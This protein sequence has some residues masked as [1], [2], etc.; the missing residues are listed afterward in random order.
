[1]NGSSPAQPM[2]WW[3]RPALAP[4]LLVIAYMVF[5]IAW[6]FTNPPGFAP[7]E[8]EHYVKAIGIAHGEVR[9]DP[10]PYTQLPIVNSQMLQWL[11][12]STRLVRVPAGMGACLYFRL[13]IDGR[14]PE[15]RPPPT[16]ARQPTYVASYPPFMYVGAAAATRLGN[17]TTT[18]LLLGRLATLL[19]SVAL[20]GAA[21]ALLGAGRGG[22][23]S[24]V[25]L[26]ASV[27]PTSVFI[28]SELSASGLEIAGGICFAAA[29]IRL[30]GDDPPPRWLWPLLLLSAVVLALSR[31][32][33]PVWVGFDVCWAVGL[34]GLRATRLRLRAHRGWA[35]ATGA[36]LV[37]AIAANVAWQMAVAPHPP[38]TLA[39][40]RSG[41][42]SVFGG[43]ATLGRQLIGVFGWIDVPLPWPAYLPWALM[44]ALLLL[45]AFLVA[46]RRQRW[47][48][49][50]VCAGIGV[51]TLGVAVVIAA[52][53]PGFQM[54]TRYV[55]P[56]AVALP[57]LAGELLRL[58]RAAIDGRLL[59]VAVPAAV[60]VAAAVQ[61]WGLEVNAQYYRHNV[62]G[63]VSY[64]TP[65]GWR[66][67]L[68]WYPW[69]ALSGLGCAAL[70]AV[71]FITTRQATPSPP[72]PTAMSQMP[73]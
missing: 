24:L 41:A 61:A 26:V 60:L 11:N 21:A 27:T 13:P 37:V 25:G 70:A 8:P 66:P 35:S 32:F 62:N 43:V 58:H 2:A 51:L 46:G 56:A 49:L 73:A 23:L 53:A 12:L 64:I 39:A 65:P 17:T 67:P 20:V 33:G 16:P 5:G 1:M 72:G 50:G 40:L 6:V 59:A 44:L 52:A 19:Q 28:F 9:G 31:T 18:A 14:C 55:L 48:L 57:L 68:G 15:G 71:A 10:A 30:T 45:G 4:L 3:R 63:Y 47:V 38:L 7:D 29:L 36:I 54:Q 22:V 42:G 34:L 69:I